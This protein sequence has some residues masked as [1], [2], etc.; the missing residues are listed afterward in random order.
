MEKSDESGLSATQFS[1]ISGCLMIIAAILIAVAL[2]YTRQIMIPFVVAL[3]LSYFLAPL[4][5]FFTKKL[6]FPHW[7]AVI[8]S[9]LLFCLAIY[10]IVMLMRHSIVLMIDS[11]YVYGAQINHIA[12]VITK[13]FAKFNIKVDQNS[14][15][16]RMKDL[17]IFSYI[18]S[19]AESAM[20]FLMDF[21]LVL[22]FLIF[23]VSGQS[24]NPRKTGLGTEI[25]AKIRSYIVMKVFTSFL[26]AL[27]VWIVLLAFHMDLASMLALIC[28]FLCF[29]PTLGPLIS[30]LLPLPIALFQLNDSFSIISVIAI[31][32]LI[33]ILIG[34]VLEPKLIGRGL[35]L[36]PI[37]ILLS[38]MFWGLIWGVAGMFLAVPITAVLKISLERIPITK[39]FSELL[40]GRSPI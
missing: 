38:L 18:Q 16:A 7:T 9:L 34:N 32:A 15:I 1:L 6:R 36:H 22:I 26:T 21:S 31:P 4:V 35:D 37:T 13:F 25:D 24:I 33:Q 2:S 10:S 14:L 40:A 17:P 8:A 30:T 39:N 29:I 20:T 5:I 23:L 28:F 11:F 3:F 27:L 12:E 19:A